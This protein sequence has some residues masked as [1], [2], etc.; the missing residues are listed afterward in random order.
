M[1]ASSGGHL[2]RNQS[3]RL[4]AALGAIIG[5]AVTAARLSRDERR[6]LLWMPAL[7]AIVSTPLYSIPP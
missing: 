4:V 7:A 3:S 5:G 1:S 6:W 2:A